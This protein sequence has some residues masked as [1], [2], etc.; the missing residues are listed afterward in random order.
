MPIC[1]LLW[2]MRGM[3]AQE[4]S[5]CIIELAKGWAWSS[6]QVTVLICTAW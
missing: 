1:R 2:A 4:C 6:T 5:L 3:A